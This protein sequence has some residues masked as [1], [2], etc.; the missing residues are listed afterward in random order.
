MTNIARAATI[1]IFLS[2][3]T[4]VP[5]FNHIKKPYA[6]HTVQRLYSVE[7]FERF[8]D[9]IKLR[10]Q[11]RIAPDG[12]RI[13]YRIQDFFAVARESFEFWILDTKLRLRKI[14][15]AAILQTVPIMRAHLSKL[16]NV[17]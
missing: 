13:F 14:D 3:D 8:L 6:E 17:L 12:I 2:I 4:I 9:A 15:F 10:S 16:R 11:V 7:G 1:I 5:S